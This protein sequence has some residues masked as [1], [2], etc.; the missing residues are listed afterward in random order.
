MRL[1][2]DYLNLMTLL[3]MEGPLHHPAW[4]L[5]KN[6]PQNNRKA[7]IA[8]VTSELFRF[9]AIVVTLPFPDVLERSIPGTEN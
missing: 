9:E 8:G 2:V 7:G 6:L 5:N 3:N 1:H 4:R